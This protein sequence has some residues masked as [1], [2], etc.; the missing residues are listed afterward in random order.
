[1]TKSTVQTLLELQQ[2]QSCNQFSIESVPVPSMLSVKNLFVYPAWTSPVT[3]LCHFLGF[4]HWSPEGRSALPLCTCLWRSHKP[5]WCLPPVSSSLGW[6]KQ[7]I[8]DTLQTS[9]PLDS[10]P[11]LINFLKVYFWICLEILIH[12][13]VS[14][15]NGIDLNPLS[16]W[17]N[18]LSIK[19]LDKKKELWPPKKTQDHGQAMYY[20]VARCGWW[21]GACNFA[22]RS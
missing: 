20:W 15:T 2:T 8:S 9:S 10:S 13:R 14:G 6:T 22:L 4:Y 21:A 1:M 3:V 11:S 19:Q 7:G 17:E 5:L 12:H 18:E 16:F